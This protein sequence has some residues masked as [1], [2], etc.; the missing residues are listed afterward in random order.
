MQSRLDQPFVRFTVTMV[1]IIAAFLLRQVLVL[2]T[3]LDLPPFITLYPAI[4][5]VALFFGLWPGLLA[6]ALAALLVDFWV[7]PPIGTLAIK[8]P[9]QAVTLAFFFATGVFISVVTEG[10]RRFQRRSQEIA[11]SRRADEALSRYRLLARH[12]R[13]IVLFLRFEDGMIL[14]ANEAAAEAYGY[15]I[16]QLKRMTIH[17]LRET[18]TRPLAPSEMAEAEMQG[19]LFE[20]LHQRADGSVFPV[21]VS[22]QGASIGGIRTL[23]SIVRDITERKRAGEALRESE[24]RYRNLF[25]AMTEGFCI[26]E[27]LFDAEGRPEDY[28]FL[29]VN[30][31]FERQTGLHDAVGKR[32]RELAPEHEA[33]WF[34]IY[35]RIALTGEPAHFMNEAKALDRFYDVRAYRVGEPEQRRVAIVFNDFSDYKRAEEALRASEAQ[36][37]AIIDGAPET[38]VFLKD[39]E[40]RFITVNSR[41]E[42]LLGVTRDEVRGKTD[43]DLLTRERADYY[44]AHDRQVLDTGKPIQIEELAQLFDGKEHTLLAS[45]FPLLDAGGKP[46]AICTISVDITERKRAEEAV[47]TS[48]ERLRL[49]LEAGAMATWDSNFLTNHFIWNDEM[50][51]LL[52]YQPGSIEPGYEPWKRRVL[53]EDFPGADARLWESI[54]TGIDLRSEYRVLGRNDEVRWIE[55]RGRSERDKNGTLVRTFGVMIDITERKRA[56]EALENN[57][58]RMAAI[59]GSAMD[60]VITIGADQRIVVF[61]TAAEK[62]F[63]CPGAEAIGDRLERFIPAVS[64]QA[65]Q[66]HIEDFAASGTTSRSM[67]SLGVLYGLR[68]SGEEFP[69]EAT[70]SQVTVSG[71]KLLT[72]IL[73]DLT[74]R[75]Q[76]EQ[77]LLRSEKLASV[78]RMAATIAHEINNP[79]AAVT[80]LL[81]V[82]KGMSD[83]PEPARQYVDMA[84]EEL[85]RVAHI[86]QQSLGFY[87]EFREPA[88]MSINEALESA[89]GLLKNKI[90]SKLAVIRKQGDEEVKITALA[91]EMRQVFANLLSN[92]LDALDEEG[93][94]TLRVSSGRAG[95]RHGVRV[96]IADNGNGIE[97]AT[98]QHVF[99]PFFTTKGSVGSGLGLWVSKQ[100]VENHGGIIQM[101]SSTVGARRGTVFSIVLPL[102]PSA[103][104]NS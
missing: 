66:K 34:E 77:A 102:Q 42:Q 76:A 40:G 43:Y 19:I 88:P 79:L 31:A 18:G 86:T 64:R 24:E 8:N 32:M 12:A 75:I 7:F 104:A 2:R 101:R 11:E 62:I 50:F 91:G 23:I 20:S 5:V 3:G 74:Q 61:N 48:E 41:F 82:V 49:A 103:R 97:A 99:E 44:R 56:E 58:K 96:T 16:E 14:E 53:P 90:R 29:E 57:Q 92:S 65:H 10:Y 4:A 73:R 37:Q 22:S 27:V 35:G 1:T 26:I 80:N 46:Y 70:I 60:A 81:F 52:G 95:N 94:I 21:E 89:L 63:G 85:K 68:A 6:T 30:D 100:I 15:T 93:V 98:R 51:H 87:R 36:L 25:S 69:L 39:V 83:L 28:R 84:D 67:H 13:D 55:T 72:V 17:D 45:K 54:E 71:E 9:S 59:I 47:R 33:H 78:G 38:I